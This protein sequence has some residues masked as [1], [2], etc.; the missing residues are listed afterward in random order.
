MIISKKAIPRRTI[1]RGL[2]TSL[3]L[4]FL[5]SMVPA[6]SAA[7]GTAKQPLRFGVTY[8][9]HGYAPGYWTPAAEGADYA[10]TIPLKPLAAFK[11]RMLVLSGLD[12]VV[13]MARQGDPRGGH[14]RMAPAFMSGV[15]CRPT[16]GADFE[17][18][19]SIDQ[20]A[21]NHIGTETQL[22]SIQ[23]SVEQV[24]FAGSCDSGYSC[25]YTNTLCWRSEKMP[26][27]MESS[28]RTVFE[29][30]FG[31]SGSTD[32]AVRL[33]RLQRKRSILDSVLERATGFNNSLGPSDR[34]LVNEYLESIRDV[35]R[36]VQLAEA[37]NDR[38]L[39]LVTQPASTPTAFADYV[40][41][42]Y[43]LNVLAFQADL[44]RVS[45]FMMA[46]ELSNRT[47]PEIGV[48]DG[49]HGLSHHGDVPEKVELLSRVNAYHAL[50]FAHF[51]DRLQATK[52]GDGTLLD[53][54]VLLYGSG[55][56]DPNIHEPK[57]LPIVLAGGG[58]VAP[59][60]GRHIHYHGEQLGNL[61]VTVLN[62]AGVPADHVG[63][64]VGPLDLRETVST[65][66]SR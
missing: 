10:L 31:D 59:G 36:R 63:D 26:L 34:T 27:P 11:D 52:D 13:A 51:L 45:T 22:P 28:P 47:Y 49:H 65:A 18:G 1:L 30:L 20:I 17:A 38:E 56:G 12:N 48:S 7:A 15:H 35:E 37:Q 5:D 44:T 16:Q 39:P 46:K 24:D 50:M 32:P 54:S 43:D 64:S 58:I 9:A 3:A 21:A 40:K 23:L 66:N 53:H 14:G 4:P 55:H 62:K 8:V 61:H 19:I 41:L 6:L 33:K 60:R 29:R 57:Q 25:V 42:M 2:G